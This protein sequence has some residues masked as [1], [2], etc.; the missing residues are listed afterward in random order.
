MP[1]AKPQDDRYENALDDVIAQC[2][3][4]TRGA[5]M[6]LLAAN[7]YLEAQLNTLHAA[8]ENGEVPLRSEKVPRNLLN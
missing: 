4:D 6:A 2:G 1:F 7:E 3:G 8:I 5:L